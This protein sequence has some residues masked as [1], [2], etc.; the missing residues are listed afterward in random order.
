MDIMKDLIRRARKRPAELVIGKN[1]VAPLAQQWRDV[2][3]LDPRTPPVTMIKQMIRDGR[4]Q[5]M[6][7]PVRVA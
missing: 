5:L 3:K 2:A 7:I 6:G 4:M 1:Q